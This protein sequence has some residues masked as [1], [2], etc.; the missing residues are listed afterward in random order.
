M[1]HFLK[2]VARA[3][4]LIS[5]LAAFVPSQGIAGG[6][7]VGEGAGIVTRLDAQAVAVT[8]WVSGPEGWDVVT[9]ID[10]LAGDET[11]NSRA[12]VRFSSR[13]LSGQSQTISVPTAVGDRHRSLTIRRVA[14]RIEVETTPTLSD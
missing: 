3:G 2:S 11:Q 13:L 12:V 7:S 10:P 1:T 5:A 9:T 14:D 4:T 6:Q 8:Y